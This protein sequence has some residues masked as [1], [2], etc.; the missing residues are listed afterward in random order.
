MKSIL[1]TGFEPFGSHEYNP[2]QTVAE[3]AA[4]AASATF[5]LLAV[6]FD[7]ALQTSFED[8]DVVV[9]VGLAARTEYVRIER[10]AH[11]LRMAADEPGQEADPDQVFRLDPDGP[12]AFE[13]PFPLAG[14]RTLL[15]PNW[16]VRLNRD[17]GTYVCNATYYWSLERSVHA[18]FIHVPEFDEDQAVAFGEALGRAVLELG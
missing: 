10:Y 13:S 16:D 17:A 3:A 7:A 2:S 12:V 5:E 15:A 11:N 1:F 6:D 9:H 14:L 4:R 8:Y 18:V